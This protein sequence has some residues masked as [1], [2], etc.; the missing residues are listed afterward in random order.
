MH[1]RPYLILRKPSSGEDRGEPRTLLAEASR[2]V[3]S[4]WS[5]LSLYLLGLASSRILDEGPWTLEVVGA[6]LGVSGA[7]LI[8]ILDLRLSR[9]RAASLLAIAVFMA[10][11]FAVLPA[12]NEL[13]LACPKLEIWQPRVLPASVFV[14]LPVL[15]VL[16]LVLVPAVWT[17][18]PWGWH[19]L[20]LSSLLHP[21]GVFVLFPVAWLLFLFLG[22]AYRE[23]FPRPPLRRP[24]MTEGTR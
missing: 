12:G 4:L 3:L 19:V 21:T 23:F 16:A 17:Y 5:I 6:A 10:S 9:P 20:L 1:L 22:L 13:C 8:G 2:V 24:R 14:G 7:V 18:R 15:L 11:W